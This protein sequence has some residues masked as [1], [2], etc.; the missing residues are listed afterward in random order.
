MASFSN[1]SVSNSH[2]V[3][4]SLEF[5]SSSVLSTRPPLASLDA[6]HTGLL[7]SG[8]A[9]HKC[10][11][12]KMRFLPV[13]KVKALFLV[14]SLLEHVFTLKTLKFSEGVRDVK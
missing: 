11:T 5:P 6:Q 14:F 2:Y 3:P 4:D 13:G 12:R 7:V 10:I 1:C 9:F 8:Q